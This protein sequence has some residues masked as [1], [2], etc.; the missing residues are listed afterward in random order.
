[1]G[2]IKMVNRLMDLLVLVVELTRKSDKSF[3]ELDKELIHLGYSTEEIEQAVFWVSSQWPRVER[4]AT[5]EAVRPSTRVLSPWETMGLSADA[6]SY[7]LRLQNLGILD[8]DQFERIMYRIL[9]F[10]GEKLDLG[11]IKA[12][13]GAV[14][15]DLGSEEFD[16]EL[17]NMLDDDIRVT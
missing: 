9:P 7:L 2:E 15:F 1:M 8:E 3:R 11:D 4:G 14:V 13:A 16:D 12:L 6:Y 10:R 5:K 17:L